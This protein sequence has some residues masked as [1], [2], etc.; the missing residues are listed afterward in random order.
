LE[1]DSKELSDIFSEVFSRTEIIQL[2]RERLSKYIHNGKKG[3]EGEIVEYNIDTDF[4]SLSKEMV[5]TLGGIMGMKLSGSKKSEEKPEKASLDKTSYE[6][7]TKTTILKENKPEDI[8]KSSTNLEESKS[9]SKN[10]VSKDLTSSYGVKLVLKYENGKAR[11][12]SV[13]SDDLAETQYVF[14][15]ESEMKKAN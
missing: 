7:V 2:V 5:K 12:V 10:S 9:P 8:E 6:N 1:I 13:P 14:S 11:F 4:G 3:K 15:N